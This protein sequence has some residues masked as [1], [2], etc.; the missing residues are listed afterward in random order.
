MEAQFRVLQLH[1]LSSLNRLRQ[2]RHRPIPEVAC[3]VSDNGLEFLPEIFWKRWR[4][5]A[6]VACTLT[7]LI[8]VAY[9]RQ[10]HLAKTI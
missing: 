5:S 9:L 4:K 1:G 2:P 8:C 6:K 7:K 10:R 3:K